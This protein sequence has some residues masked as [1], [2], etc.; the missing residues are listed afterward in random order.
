M[1]CPNFT[2]NFSKPSIIPFPGKD[3]SLTMYDG[4][5]KSLTATNPRLVSN[6]NIT[7]ANKS[8]SKERRQHN[9]QIKQH[10]PVVIQATQCLLQE[11]VYH[12]NG[13]KKY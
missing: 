10:A 3:Q 6:A 8:L 13:K 4:H 9:Q 5:I 12:I 7:T 2:P 1:F 11:Q